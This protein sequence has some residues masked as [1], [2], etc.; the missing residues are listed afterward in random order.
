[1]AGSLTAQILCSITS[2]RLTTSLSLLAPRSHIKHAHKPRKRQRRF[3]RN[4]AE[5]HTYTHTHTILTP[6]HTTHTPAH[7]LAQQI[8][9]NTS[10]WY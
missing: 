3:K 10:N 2:S 9:A 4:L 5:V 8:H 6:H 1:M 7:T